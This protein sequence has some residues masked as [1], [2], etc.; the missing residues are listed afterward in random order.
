MPLMAVRSS[1]ARPAKA[2][3]Y[4][5]NP[6]KAAFISVQNLNPDKD[7]AE[8]FENTAKF[9]NKNTAY[10]DRKYYHFK[11]SPNPKDGVTAE[12]CQKYAE[13]VCSSL[14]PNFECVVAT[15]TDSGVIHSHVIINSV[16]F[17]TGLK[18]HATDKEYG[19]MKDIA[20]EIGLKHGMSVTNWRT[21]SAERLTTTEAHLR[22]SGGLSWKDELREVITIAKKTSDNIIEF[23]DVL[24]E[25]GVALSRVTAN[26]ISY[27]H[28]EHK[29]AVRGERLGADFTKEA[30]ELSFLEKEKML[31]L[32]GEI[33]YR[34]K[35]KQAIRLSGM[36]SM[37]YITEANQRYELSV[38]ISS[39]VSQA[40][41]KEN[42]VTILAEKYGIECVFSEET[43][44]YRRA[45]TNGWINGDDL[46]CGKE[47]FKYVIDKQ[48]HGADS[49]GHRSYVERG[50]RIRGAFDERN[51]RCGSTD[52]S[53]FE[54]AA[55]TATHGL[56]SGEGEV[57]SGHE[58]YVHTTNG[59]GDASVGNAD[60]GNQRTN[61]GN[62]R[63]TEGADGGSVRD[64]E[65]E[66]SEHRANSNNPP[67]Q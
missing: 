7:F 33:S 55:V 11:L 45:D 16:S 43:V 60:V 30:I 47:K 62:R 44:F 19:Q 56:P 10:S 57:T 49:R 2:I 58:G 3:E 21:P 52:T 32:S 26:T 38:I 8:Q 5:T 61:G 40:S 12:Q 9:F 59:R 15:H 51:G 42:F 14:F 48:T 64:T 18:F 17:E 23:E 22:L 67:K 46:N 29:Q 37:A 6:S 20:N 4:I 1:L 27:L 63:G 31:A 13:A 24:A 35:L 66:V 34:E 65:G 36:N 54:Q 50:S 53:A 28:P 39:A 25:Y 41:S